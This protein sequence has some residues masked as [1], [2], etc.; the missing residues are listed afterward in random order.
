MKQ[1]FKI[2]ALSAA[3]MATF[4]SMP[5]YAA[6]EVKSAVADTKELSEIEVRRAKREADKKNAEIEVIE[7]TGFAGSLRKAMNAKRFNDG[8]SDSIHA[9]DVGKSTDQN[10]AD[11]LSRVTG[12]TVQSDGGEGTRISVRG[13]GAS[14]NQIS[15]NGVALTSGLN[16]DGTDEGTVADTSVDLSTFSADILSS[17]DVQ[18][19][20]AADQDEGSLGASVVL[21]TVRP[22]NLNKRRANVTVEGRYNDYSGKNDGRIVGSFADKFLDDSL[23]FVLTATMDKQKTRQD[24]L[25][26]DWHERT[27]QIKDAYDANGLRDRKA[28]DLDGNIIRVTGVDAEG[29]P[30]PESSLLTPVGDGEVL[31]LGNVDVL[32]KQLNNIQVNS[33]I[34]KRFSLSGGIQWQPGDDT[35]IQLDFTKS[36]QTVSTDNH[37]ISLNYAPITQGVNSA[38]PLLDFNT[39]DLE[40]RTL[41]KALGTRASGGLVR[42]SGDRE[43]DT[44]V[45]SLRID[46]QLT[47]NLLMELSAGYSK[48]TDGTDNSVRVATAT[49]GTIQGASD[50]LIGSGGEEQ[51][52]YDCAATRGRDCSFSTGTI[53]ATFDPL[54][55]SVTNLH[56]SFNPFDVRANHLGGLT[57][58]DNQ[59]SDTNKSLKIDFTW[60]VEAFDFITGVKFGAKYQ[61]RVKDVQVSNV[62]VSNG[63][64]LQDNSDGNIEYSTTGMQSIRVSDMLSSEAFPYDN[65]ADGLVSDRSNP[66]FQ[67]W[68]MLDAD[69]AIEAFSN[70]EA[71]SVGVNP[72]NLGTRYINTDSNAAYVKIN[73]EALEGKLTGN[74][75]LR[76]VKDETYARGVGG[77]SYTRRPHILDPYDLLITRGLGDQSLPVCQDVSTI[78]RGLL[79]GTPDT[80]A[81]PA[82]PSEV[83]N[84]YAWQLT[85]GYHYQN[86]DSLPYD[87]DTNEWRLGGIDVNNLVSG[88]D[89]SGATPNYSNAVFT[90]LPATVQGVDENGNPVTI[91][92][93]ARRHRDF[94]SVGQIW[95]WFDLSTAFSGPN[96][97]QTNTT[98]REA[99]VH[100]N[101][102][103]SLLLPSLNINYAVNDEMIVRFAASKTMA[104]PTFDGLV[105]SFSINEQPFDARFDGQG[106]NTQ[107]KSLESKNLDISWE[108]YFNEASILSVAL[109]TKDMTNFQEGVATDFHFKDVRSEYELQ[110][111]DLLL[112]YDESRLP[113]EEGRINPEDDNCQPIRFYAGFNASDWYMGCELALVTLQ[114]NGEGAST[115]GVEIGYTQSYDFLP[116]VL[117]GFGASVNY[118]YQD[119]S[120]DPVRIGTT[121][122]F[123]QSLPQPFT[124]K[125]SANATVFWEKDGL[126]FRLANRY[127]DVQLVERGNSG[128]ISWEDSSNRLDFSSS[129]KI[130]D[131]FT[132]TF[133]ATNL[134]NE[135]TRRFI[136]SSSA[137]DAGDLGTITHHEGNVVEDSSITTDRTT[138]IFKNGRQFRLGVRAVF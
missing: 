104:R 97:D 108:W 32:T 51:I 95:P 85:H 89:Y 34:R 14:L 65:F 118:T 105:P 31:V 86:A 25:N 42:N 6:E 114:T 19:T 37:Q 12:V 28:R 38:D 127:T 91:A 131:T 22:L 134:T 3:I 79:N 30:N 76:Y 99:L 56:S 74:V 50:T 60:D 49:W 23:G 133:N 2:K 48:T 20:S 130:N 26:T 136:T 75:G 122:L 71:G 70:R 54:D 128:I 123:L 82:N 81:T 96:G 39:V 110:N 7:V 5:V 129:Y 61:T 109:F 132:V 53:P 15:M 100:D 10:I 46:H 45:L 43:I 17:I 84:C 120:S 72:N 16:G 111:G 9:E 35:D 40:S 115:D 126:M 41:V 135:V 92:S 58:R 55:G 138:S 47:D 66:F 98:R 112:D 11:A 83:N 77:I 24:R 93:D 107:L 36:T 116:G 8:V 117:S 80:R 44:D 18:K 73:F 27:T 78:E 64:T 113:G 13:A 68:P 119:S 63:N 33:D 121:D 124:P 69:K 1:N 88:I 59:Q 106:G 101:G 94:R 90:A 137:R 57:F 62:L 21:Q 52:G 102:E 87:Y 67:G 103:S 4:I 29:N 125:H